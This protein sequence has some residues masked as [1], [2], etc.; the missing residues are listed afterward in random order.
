MLDIVLFRTETGGDP[1][2]V[3][4]SQRRRG[5]NVDLVTT[6]VELDEQWRAQL[7]LI[8][9][10]RDTARAEVEAAGLAAKAAA[11]NGSSADLAEAK[12]SAGLAKRQLAK[13]LEPLERAERT[14]RTD[15]H[16]ALVG[17]GALV[18]EHAP[19][20]PAMLG[21]SEPRTGGAAAHG[22][23][24]SHSAAAHVRAQRALVAA[25]WAELLHA[26]SAAPPARVWRTRG[27]AL[28]AQ[29][30]MVGLALAAAA[31][32]GYTLLPWPVQSPAGVSQKLQKLRQDRGELP[33]DGSAPPTQGVSSVPTGGSEG[34]PIRALHAAS[35]LL[36]KEL[37][38]R[39]AY[40]VDG[41][42]DDAN[43][44]GGAGPHVY[45]SELWP[46]DGS[47]WE[48]LDEVGRL[49][50]AVHAQLG[51]PVGLREAHT[52]ELRCEEARAFV[53]ES[54]VGV[55]G[56][57]AGTHR[58]RARAPD[59]TPAEPSI[60]LARVWC[61]ADYMPRGL[62]IRCGGKRIGERHKRYVHMV[63]ARICSPTRC[64]L[65]LAA[66][67]PPSPLPAVLLRGLPMSM[68]EAE[69]ESRNAIRSDCESL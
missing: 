66:T 22:H 48:A 34:E 15:L 23:S 16:S 14:L 3:R 26:P 29:H 58:A 67:S 64:L 24:T 19:L 8:K 6:V 43:G 12:A 40:V 50:E 45:V 4:E 11:V 68:P 9:A 41:T 27:P 38:V 39:Y 69:A 65:A 30:T 18:H 52:G 53:L 17:I 36:E 13:R 31:R 46:D 60:E 49:S 21:M 10:T 61:T 47:A 25:G 7:Q 62:G 20:R 55:E 32:A 59:G 56:A 57:V 1:D 28:L 51:L 63:G 2:V 54:S 44:G 35:W 5:A 42:A 37:P 33:A